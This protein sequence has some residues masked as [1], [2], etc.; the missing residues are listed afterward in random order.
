[1]AK[2]GFGGEE[3][4]AKKDEKV[5]SQGGD[6]NKTETKDKVAEKPS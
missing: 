1:M 2:K 4:P 5:I 6:P 3:D